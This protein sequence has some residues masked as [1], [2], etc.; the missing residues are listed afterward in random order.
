[1]STVHFIDRVIAYENGD[2]D[3]EEILELFQALVNSG[4]AWQLQG[5]Y[6]RVA[7]QLLDEGLIHL[8]E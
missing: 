4:A 1:M 7:K 2:L 3:E 6:G 5:H 8:P